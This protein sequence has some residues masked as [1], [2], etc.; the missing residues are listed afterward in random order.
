M[1]TLPESTMRAIAKQSE[2]DEVLRGIFKEHFDIPTNED[3]EKDPNK[4]GYRAWA[5]MAIEVA[6]SMANMIISM[7]KPESGRGLRVMQDLVYALNAN[8]FWAKNAP[9]LVPILTVM[10][11]A[12][13]DGVALKVDAM[14]NSEYT[15]YDKLTSATQLVPLEIF[16]MILYLVGGPMLMS[17]RSLPLKIALAPYLV[18]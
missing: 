13:K 10:C 1:N 17:N 18:N 2:V 9:I 7:R 6:V 3:I 16:S 15:I 12:H 8:D 11:N 14:Q 4:M 5:M